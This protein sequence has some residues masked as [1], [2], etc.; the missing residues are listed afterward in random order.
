MEA[1]GTSVP[2]RGRGA[3]ARPFLCEEGGDGPEDG[4]DDGSK[5]GLANL[6]SLASV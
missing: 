5:G 2:G 1:L 6:D 3:T 4:D